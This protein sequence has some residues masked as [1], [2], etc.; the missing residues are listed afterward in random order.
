MIVQIVLLYA[1]ILVLPAYLL[2]TL[3][4]RREESTFRWLLKLAYTGAFLIY[5]FLAGRWDWVSTYLRYVWLGL[6][7]V[8]AAISYR[9]LGGHL[10]LRSGTLRH[11]RPGHP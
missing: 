2:Y 11:L 4:R 1:M 5:V 3:A 9:Q 7:A 6:Y 8:A 10:P